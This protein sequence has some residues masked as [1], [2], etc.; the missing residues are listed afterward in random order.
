MLTHL[1]LLMS[2]LSFLSLT[3]DP[4]SDPDDPDVNEPSP[5]AGKKSKIE[6]TDE[7]N[8]EIGRIV[9]RETRKAKDAGRAERDAE[10]AAEK[11][12]ADAEAKRK[13]DE[14]AG[15]FES[16]K[17]SLTDER[18]AAKAELDVATKERDALQELVKADVDAQWD[19]LPEEVRSTFEGADDD[20]LAKKR[21]MQRMKSI[22]DRLLAVSSKKGTPG[23]P[24]PA[25]N[26]QP[27][28]ESPIS[29]RD[30]LNF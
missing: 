30:I 25:G 9:S 3:T 19:E 5:G 14:D 17:Q 13:A 15:L 27:A 22:I 16:V 8:A 7:Q 4:N 28:A 23:N 29:A 21:H 20:V 10:I 6:F 2:L 18:D 12:A 24:P 11:A 26:Q 1:R